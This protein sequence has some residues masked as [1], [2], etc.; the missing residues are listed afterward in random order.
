MISNN[1]KLDIILQEKGIMEGRVIRY[2][3]VIENEHN[4]FLFTHRESDIGR[5]S[6]GY[7]MGWQL[8]STCYWGSNLWEEDILKMAAEDVTQTTRIPTQW[9]DFRLINVFEGYDEEKTLN[10]VYHIQYE[11][12]SNFE[13]WSD[14]D[15]DIKWLVIDEAL[16]FAPYQEDKEILQMVKNGAIDLLNGHYSTTTNFKKLRKLMATFVQFTTA[17]VGQGYA[18]PTSP[19]FDLQVQTDDFL[20]EHVFLKAFPNYIQFLKTYSGA[21]ISTPNGSIHFE[22][23][24]FIEE[25]ALPIIDKETPVIDEDGYYT[26][27][28]SA[29]QEKGKDKY[30]SFAFDAT[31]KRKKGV[32]EYIQFRHNGSSQYFHRYP[33]FLSWLEEIIDLIKGK[34]RNK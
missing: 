15:D 10:I 12:T 9:A 4:E 19:K 28:I 21:S 3:Y 16:Q 20:N 6:G 7:Y 34:I 18:H 27:C 24:G 29:M 5:I 32:Y 2:V 25:I 23:G 33:S 8:C 30:L 22:I 13:F 14:S 11:D 1:T 17:K 26:F 31:G